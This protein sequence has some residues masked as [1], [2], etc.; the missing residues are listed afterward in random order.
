VITNLKVDKGGTR[1]KRLM[2]KS[3][4]T[5]ATRLMKR[6]IWL[7]T[8]TSSIRLQAVTIVSVGVT[9]AMPEAADFATKKKR[10]DEVV[11]VLVSALVL[12]VGELEV[13]LLLGILIGKDVTMIGI[14][15]PNR[16]L[17]SGDKANCHPD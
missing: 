14:V 5:P 13:I 4:T 16:L 3:A 7:K 15:T 8:K 2:G 10:S 6:G 17:M 9:T 12:A 11:V 1:L